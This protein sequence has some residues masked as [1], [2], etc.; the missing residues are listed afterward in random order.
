MQIKIIATN[1]VLLDATNVKEVYVPTSS[2]IVGILPQYTNYLATL[3]IGELKVLVGNDWSKYII[4]GGFVQVVKDVVLVLADDAMQPEALVKD[5]IQEAISN[6]EQKLSSKLEPAELIRLEK[7]LK[8]E[9][10]KS[11]YVGI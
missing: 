2:G 3:D 7:I 5:E 11:Q 6:A 8:Y 4:N 10:F 9:K 1:K